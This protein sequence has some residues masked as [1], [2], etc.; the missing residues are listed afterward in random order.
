MVRWFNMDKYANRSSGALR[1]NAI[2]D[3]KKEDTGSEPVTRTE[4]K[5]HINNPHPDDD[6]MIDKLISASR[7]AI[8][9]FTSISIRP[10]TITAILDNYR[11][12]MELPYGPVLGDVEVLSNDEDGD[13]IEDAVIGVMYK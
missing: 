9:N 4:A 2:I 10:K 11:G 1:I 7:I 13:E 3:I 5:E 8:E 12:D 6:T